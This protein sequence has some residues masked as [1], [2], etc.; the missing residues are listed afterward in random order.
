MESERE[1]TERM[2]TSG[3]GNGILLKTDQHFHKQVGIIRKRLDSMH[4]VTPLRL[5]PAPLPPTSPGSIFHRMAGSSIK[6]SASFYSLGDQTFS[7]PFTGIFRNK[8]FKGQK[9][10]AALKT[11]LHLHL[12]NTHLTSCSCLICSCVRI[13]VFLTSKRATSLVTFSSSKI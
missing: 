9:S 11:F 5:Q 1:V 10:K 8:L 3:L 4:L 12:Y 13:R 7:S 2:M 6:V